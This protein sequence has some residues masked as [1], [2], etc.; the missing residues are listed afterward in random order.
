MT[1]K[2]V[3]VHVEPG[4]ASEARLKYAVTLAR[5]FEARLTGLTVTLPPTEI[6]S[7]MMGDA[8]LFNAALQ[9]SEEAAAL[10]RSQ[11]SKL[12]ADCGLQTGW[13][14]GEGNPPDVVSAEAGCADL[15]IL[16]SKEHDVMDGGVYSLSPADV[17]MTC[18]RPILVLPNR[19]SAA[20]PPKRILVAW[21]NTGEAARAIHDALPILRMATEVILTEIVSPE[22][23]SGRYSIPINDVADHLRTHGVTV[24]VRRI[25]GES[26]DAGALLLGLSAEVEADMI[27]AGAY[28]HSRL[29][30]WA[31]GGVTAMLLDAAGIPCLFSH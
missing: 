29:R 17:L 22:T 27:V 28:G 26:A 11:F 23:W 12:M 16:G 8:Q 30:E 15:V 1:I 21:K 9:A 5:A 7:A 24:A 18:G 25:K 3:L 14:N 13:R 19:V 4:L 31:L 6:P 10:A 2:Q 20:F